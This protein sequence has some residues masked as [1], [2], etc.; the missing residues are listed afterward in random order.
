MTEQ[1]TKS[2]ETK[3]KPVKQ[4]QRFAKEAIIRTLSGIDVFVAEEILAD[5]K[6][7]SVEEAEKALAD[8]KKG[9]FK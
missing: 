3:E 9:E 4:Q 5:D 2:A 1:K 8:W 6:Q 7:Y